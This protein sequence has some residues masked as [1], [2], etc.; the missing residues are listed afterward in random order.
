LVAGISGTVSMVA[1]LANLSVA[2]VIPPITVIGTA[3]AAV[4][5]LWP[6][7]AQLLIRFTGP[8]LWWLTHVAG[9]SSALPGAVVP[10]PSGVAGVVVVAVV[11]IASVLLWRYGWGRA[12]LVTAMVC[13]VSWTL[14]GHGVEAVGPP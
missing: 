6:A 4:C 3:A 14:S 11:G 2:M 12:V 7:A 8:E 5:A 9:W 10:V 13:L 1:V